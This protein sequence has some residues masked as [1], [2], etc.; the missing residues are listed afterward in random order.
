MLCLAVVLSVM[1]MGAEA[2]NLRPFAARHQHQ[3]QHHAATIPSLQA[4]KP[5][6]ERHSVPVVKAVVAAPARVEEPPPAEDSTLPDDAVVPEPEQPAPMQPVAPVQP[7]KPAAAKLVKPVAKKHKA[8]VVKAEQPAAAGAV[9]QLQSDLAE[10]KQMHK[11]VATVEQ[12]LAADVALLR[13]TATLQKM[14]SSTGTRAAA[15]VQ[16][17]QAEQLVKA[18]ETMVL[19]SRG[20]AEERAKAALREAT[21]VQKAVDALVE[22]AKTQ[23]AQ[24]KAKAAKPAA[25]APVVTPSVDTDATADAADAVDDTAM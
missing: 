4:K 5:F 24:V 9:V 22:E 20:D 10:V 15:N 25:A 3:H 13:E 18:T 6:A 7:A 21:E 16:L 12:T 17:H 19:K 23:V 8:V 14:A 11:N 1:A 2:N